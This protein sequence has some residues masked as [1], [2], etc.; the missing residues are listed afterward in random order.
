MAIAQT[1]LCEWEWDAGAIIGGLKWGSYMEQ[2][3][4]LLQPAAIPDPSYRSLRQYAAD[5]YQNMC[6]YVV[7]WVFMWC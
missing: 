2:Y 7:C 4:L 1:T 5:V 3:I 6:I